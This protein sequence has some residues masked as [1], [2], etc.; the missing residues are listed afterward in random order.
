LESWLWIWYE[1]IITPMLLVH[2][3]RIDL[4]LRSAWNAWA[5]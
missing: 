5:P 4:I 2:I 3:Q 1:T